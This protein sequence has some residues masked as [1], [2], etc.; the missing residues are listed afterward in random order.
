MVSNQGVCTEGIKVGH[1]D[2]V[3]EDGKDHYCVDPYIWHSFP[4]V[5]IG[6]E[7]FRVIRNAFKIN[8]CTFTKKTCV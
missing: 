8:L 1:K 7:V 5:I 4:L 6:V 2:W 3:R